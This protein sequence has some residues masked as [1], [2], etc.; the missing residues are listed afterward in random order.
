MI[1]DIL[2]WLVLIGL[3]GFTLWVTFTLES[4]PFSGSPSL[5][6]RLGFTRKAEQPPIKPTSNDTPAIDPSTIEL[7]PE[8]KL[9]KNN[10]L[11]SPPFNLK[12]K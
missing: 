4:Y 9:D 6:Q 10:R 2:G 7:Y 11:I 5:I 12:R 3:V 1:W 8:I